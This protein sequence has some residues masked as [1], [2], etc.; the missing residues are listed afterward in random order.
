MIGIRELR[1]D[2]AAAVRRQSRGRALVSAVTLVATGVATGA[3]AMLA[4]PEVI[5]WR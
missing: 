1:A 4:Q 2:L 3:S 5:G